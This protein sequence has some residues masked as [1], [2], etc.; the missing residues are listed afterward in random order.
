MAVIRRKNTKRNSFINESINIDSPEDYLRIAA[1][2]SLDISPLDIDNLVRY[3][4]IRIRREAMD[5]DISG[6]LKQTNDGWVIGVNNLHHPRRQRFTLAHELAHYALHKN[7]SN[8][9]EDKVLFR[10]LEFNSMEIEANEFAAELLMPEA[11]FTEY[12]KNHSN[13]INDIANNFDVSALAVRM[14]AKK[15]GFKGHG[16]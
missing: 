3:L 16:L 13:N 6:Y 15:L 5:D 4:G 8:N 11:E 10:S 2:Q 9:F 1:E 12:I 14:R 7:T